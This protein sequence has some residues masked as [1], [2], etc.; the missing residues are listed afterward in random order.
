MCDHRELEQPDKR[1]KIEKKEA[2]PRPVGGGGLPGAPP[3]LAERKAPCYPADPRLRWEVLTPLPDGQPELGG[4]GTR[5]RPQGSM[6]IWLRVS[7]AKAAVFPG[8]TPASGACGNFLS[9]ES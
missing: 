4:V 6:G 7:E 9:R 5:P 8:L 1:R 3:Q 2:N